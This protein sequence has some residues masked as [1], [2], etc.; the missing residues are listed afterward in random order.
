MDTLRLLCRVPG[1]A[2][3]G[4]RGLALAASVLLLLNWGASSAR[5]DLMQ[6]GTNAYASISDILLGGGDLNE[7]LDGSRDPFVGALNSS[8]QAL[9]DDAVTLDSFG[10]GPWDRG[11]A[12]S[13]ATLG[14]ATNEIPELKAKVVLT[15]NTATQPSSVT[16]A[17]G[18]ARAS[19]VEL[20][21][22]TGPTASTLT[23]TLT[24]E[25]TVQEHFDGSTTG[26]FGSLG[27]FEE[28]DDFTYAND[29]GTIFEFDG[30]YKQDVT[31]GGS[32]GRALLNLSI[33]LDTNGIEETVTGDVTISVVPDEVF[34]VFTGLSA[35]AD[36]ED[37]FADAFGT[38][39]AT[40]DDPSVVVIHNVV[41]PEPTA[42]LLW[43]VGS[44]LI[45][46]AKRR[47]A[48]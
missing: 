24:L 32:G 38:L 5:A 8:S 2:R 34:Y 25:G 10:N 9:V 19:A 35:R 3:G 1:G 30:D 42:G 13:S 23:L 21:Q 6:W 47:R 45:V 16:G 33:P 36:D 26:L 29:E 22:Y 28:N 41:I 7:T 15:G 12:E 39:K 31:P 40:F 44:L 46:A 18:F 37:N 4:T 27:V 20:F 48:A 17:R 14:F 11:V 43:G